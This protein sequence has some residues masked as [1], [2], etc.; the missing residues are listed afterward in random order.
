M[1]LALIKHFMLVIPIL[2]FFFFLFSVFP[3]SL[4]SLCFSSV[5]R[6]T[7]FV[8]ISI[9]SLRTHSRFRCRCRW[10]VVSSLMFLFV[11]Q[12]SV[13]VANVAVAL[14]TRY[15]RIFIYY[16]IHFDVVGFIWL[17]VTACLCSC[18]TSH[19]TYNIAIWERATYISF[20]RIVRSFVRSFVRLLFYKCSLYRRLYRTVV[21]LTSFSTISAHSHSHSFRIQTRYISML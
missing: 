20:V 14:K 6:K 4:F 1:A 17:L 21:P 15:F 18:H 8:L 19:V 2:F 10:C 11:L 3:F 13:L 5:Y 16:F 7:V 12:R 9:F